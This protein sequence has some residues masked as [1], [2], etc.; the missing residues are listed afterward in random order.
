MQSAAATS[1]HCEPMELLCHRAAAL[2]KGGT[3]FKVTVTRNDI[4]CILDG[5]GEREGIKVA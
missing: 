1:Q 5:R 4:I 2:A 3:N